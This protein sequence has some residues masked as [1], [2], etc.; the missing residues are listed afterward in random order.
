MC[1]K[2]ALGEGK[3]WL[4]VTHAT[5]GGR[6]TVSCGGSRSCWCS[7]CWPPQPRRTGSS[8]APAGSAWR[9]P[10]RSRTRPR[11]RRPRGWPCPS[12]TRRRRSPASTDASSPLDAAK[13][14]R[15]LAGALGDPD[16]GPHVLAAVAQLDDATAGL[17]PRVGRRHAGL[18]DEA[19][20]HDRRARDAGPGPHVLHARRRRRRQPDRAGR[21]W[22]PV[23]RQP[24]RR[25]HGVPAPGGRGDPG[26]RHRPRAARRR[27]PPGA[28]GVRRLAV[29]RS[30]GR[31]ALAGR[32]RARRRGRARSVPSGSTRVG[33]RPGSAGSRTRRRPPRPPSPRRWTGPGSRSSATPAPAG[34][35]PQAAPLASVESAPLSEIVEQVLSV[36]DNEGAEVLGHH[37][38][39]ATGGSG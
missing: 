25:R 30:A 17:H 23:P 24:A 26:P 39:I 12:R 18:H 22:R 37:V 11:W 33:P 19:A 35:T 20:D 38:G 2:R 36:S 16:L 4:D 31:P 29:H 28:P 3:R 8:S 5:L 14:R 27:H 6:A 13:V 34:R 10:T 1:R 21:R 9:R 15:A 32:L 7:C